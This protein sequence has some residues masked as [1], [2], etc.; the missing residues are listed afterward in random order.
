M[1]FARA[2]TLSNE[3]PRN[4][5]MFRRNSLMF[6]RLRPLQKI[7]LRDLRRVERRRDLRRDLRRRER[8]ERERRRNLRR[9]E[10]RR[11]LGRDLRRVERRDRL[12][13]IVFVFNIEK[14]YS[15]FLEKC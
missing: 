4:S 1:R 9:V 3:P 11:D 13:G 8:R 7:F 14:K 15:F 6:G 5:N 12:R 2:F 10:R